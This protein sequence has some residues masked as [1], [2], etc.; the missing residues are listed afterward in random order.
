MC[1]SKRRKVLRV[2]LIFLIT[3]LILFLA[4]IYHGLVDRRYVVA[5]GMLQNDDDI[6]IALITDLH[7][8]AHGGDQQPLIRMIERM[9]PDLICLVGDIA[10]DVN[11]IRSTELLLEGITGIAPCV[12]ATGNHEYWGD[13]ET[14]FAVFDRFGVQTLRN[15]TAQMTIKGQTLTLYGIDDPYYSRPWDYEQF[16]LN[17]QPPDD[18]SFTI[19]LSHRPDPIEMFAT[20]GFDLVLSGHTHG[21]QVRVPLVVNGL[22]APDQGWF[23]KYAGGRYQVGDT[24]LIIS[25]G[26]SYYEDLPRIFNPPEVVEVVLRA[27]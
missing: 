25:R 24:T 16:L 5:S 6:R 3:L 10:D 9:R 18:G 19:L 27:R 23:P 2:L 11:P 13:Y 1:M 15:E 21:G 26:L 4:A 12:Y 17:W 20:K 22:Y 14:M 7:S 8:Y